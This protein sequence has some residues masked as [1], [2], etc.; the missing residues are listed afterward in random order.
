[1]ADAWSQVNVCLRDQ[2]T[3]RRT[4]LSEQ[5]IHGSNKAAS[6]QANAPPE[7]LPLQQL[8]P[9]QHPAAVQDPQS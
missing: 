1:M 8:I 3:V 2:Q 4:W 7:R 6:S 9:A 5:M